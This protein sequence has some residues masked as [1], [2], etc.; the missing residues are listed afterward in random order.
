[1]SKAARV[2]DYA[3]SIAAF[4]ERTGADENDW[5]AAAPS[6]TCRAFHEDVPA[7]SVAVLCH[8]LRFPPGD[9]FSDATLRDVLECD[10]DALH[11]ALLPLYEFGYCAR[12][13]T[14]QA[15]HMTILEWTVA[16]KTPVGSDDEE[17]E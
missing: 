10:D 6:L 3:E 14:P 15:V 5:R 2:D 11:A 12:V 7:E 4:L 13:V 16:P 8:V 9:G 1:M 17:S